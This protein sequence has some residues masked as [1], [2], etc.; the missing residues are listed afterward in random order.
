MKVVLRSVV[1]GT[2]IFGLSVLG[3]SS[4]GGNV[5]NITKWLKQVKVTH[6]G[7]PDLSGK[8]RETIRLYFEDGWEFSIADCTDRYPRFL[9]A[10]TNLYRL[11][12]GSFRLI[13]GPIMEFRKD[14]M[15][16]FGVYNETSLSLGQAKLEGPVQLMWDRHGKPTVGMTDHRLHWPIR[17]NL[18]AGLGGSLSFHPTRAPEILIG[19][20]LQYQVDKD[21]SF[22]FRLGQFVSGNAKGSNQVRVDYVRKL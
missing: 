15:T 12:K 6:V 14:Q 1:I 9:P 5:P 18:N 19:L 22:R 8:G 21:N 13:G 20:W 4:S 11:E 2:T 10:K 7:A 16:G 17:P 3:F